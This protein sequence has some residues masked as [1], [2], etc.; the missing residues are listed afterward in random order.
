M[1]NRNTSTVV[2]EDR[3]SINGQAK[4]VA[5]VISE[6]KDELKDFA[7]T[8]ITMLRTEMTLKLQSFKM[9]APTLVVGLAL[10][11]TA[12]MAFTGCLICIIAEAFAPSAWAYV[13]SF[14][15]VAVLYAIIGAMATAYAVKRMKETGVKP[16][17]TIRV[18]EQDR[19]WMQTEA[20]TQL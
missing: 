14:I 18:L 9:A 11:W 8:R 16:Q 3:S 17:R 19:I 13:I 7:A 1:N 6:L 5:E 10:L 20:R 15:I 12:W 2:M 4:T